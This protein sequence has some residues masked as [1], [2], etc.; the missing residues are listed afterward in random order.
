[1]AE[2]TQYKEIGTEF[3]HFRIPTDVTCF[4]ADLF[5]W[6]SYK[7]FRSDLQLYKFPTEDSCFISEAN[8]ID[9]LRDVYNLKTD[10]YLS[11]TDSQP[12][13]FDVL[14]I[15]LDQT[16]LKD[17]FNNTPMYMKEYE[18]DEEQ[19]VPEDIC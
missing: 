16:V 13:A 19:E 3:Q 7:E 9:N 11:F 10:K 18:E 8:V 12:V 6:I 1:M 14:G 17:M 15:W 2:F 4:Y 5:H